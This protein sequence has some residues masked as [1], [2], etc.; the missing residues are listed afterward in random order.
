MNDSEDFKD[1]QMLSFL[2]AAIVRVVGE[3]ELLRSEMEAWYSE[4]PSSPFPWTKDLIAKD[5][6][7]SGLDDQFKT[8]WDRLQNSPHSDLS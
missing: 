3:R 8:L 1:Q 5:E 7:L 4:N 6:E 2:K